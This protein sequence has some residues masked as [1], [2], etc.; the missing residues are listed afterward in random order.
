MMKSE[1]N[2]G[3]LVAENRRYVETVAKLY[4]NRGLISQLLAIG[5]SVEVLEPL[6]L[7]EEIKEK[8]NN[9]VNFYK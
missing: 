7:R 4:L 1:T 9:M 6:E 3:K 5:D 2:Q 8:I